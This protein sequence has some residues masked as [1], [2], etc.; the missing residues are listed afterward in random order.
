MNQKWSKKDK[1]IK[2]LEIMWGLKETTAGVEW[3][4][5][6]IMDPKKGKT[7]RCKLKLTDGGEKLD[8]RGFMG[9]TLFGRTQTWQREKDAAP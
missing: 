6:E 4:G 8:V 5:G 3:T 9:F 1:L 7:Y 2:G